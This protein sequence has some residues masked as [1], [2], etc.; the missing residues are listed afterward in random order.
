V[1]RL[2]KYYETMM[3]DWVLTVTAGSSAAG[4]VSEMSMLS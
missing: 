4:N 1:S 3:T 2:S